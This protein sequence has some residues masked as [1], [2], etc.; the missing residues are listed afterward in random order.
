MGVT[1]I[2]GFDVSRAILS[3]KD[4]CPTLSFE[5]TCPLREALA[6]GAVRNNAPA[7]VMKRD[8][9]ILVLPSRQMQPHR[10]AQGYMSGQPWMVVF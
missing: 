9:R 6:S 2:T 10:V 7:L 1:G 3:D 5:S 4:V 8:G